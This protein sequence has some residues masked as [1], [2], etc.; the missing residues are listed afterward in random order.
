MD[1]AVEAAEGIVMR[2]ID[3]FKPQPNDR[4]EVSDDCLDAVT[5]GSSWL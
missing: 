2:V 3:V 1:K 5:V 4:I